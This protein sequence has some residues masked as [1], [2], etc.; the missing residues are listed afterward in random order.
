MA[1]V[2][3]DISAP[4]GVYATLRRAANG[5]LLL[6]VLAP[7]GFKDASIG[8]MRQEYVP[9]ANVTVRILVPPERKPKAMRSLRAGGGLDFTLSEGYAVATIPNLHVGEVVHLE[10]A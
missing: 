4:L 10:L 7:V 5:D 9:I 8:R 3:F 1:A 2:P 6:W